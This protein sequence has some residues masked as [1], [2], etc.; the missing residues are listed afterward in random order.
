MDTI[1]VADAHYRGS[2]ASG[3]LA[4]IAEHLHAY[5]SNGIRNPS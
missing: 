1:E 3:Y 2:Q 4:D 5:I